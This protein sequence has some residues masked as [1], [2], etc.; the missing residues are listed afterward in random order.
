MVMLMAHSVRGDTFRVW[1]APLRLFHWVLVAAI[2][3]AFLSSEEDSP[4]AAWHMTAG[5]ISAVL[6]VFR[7]VWGFVGGEHARFADFLRPSGLLSDPAAIRPSTDY[8]D[9]DPG[10]G[11]SAIIIEQILA[12]PGEDLPEEI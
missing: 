8:A 4:I 2:A 3:V 11:H 7:L 6:L 9:P 12:I 1:D 5:W 10:T